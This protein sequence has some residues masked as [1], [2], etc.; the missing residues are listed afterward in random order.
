MVFLCSFAALILFLA[1]LGLRACKNKRTKGS[2]IFGLICFVIF[3]WILVTIVAPLTFKGE[4]IGS[5]TS[6]VTYTLYSQ[7][8]LKG[9]YAYL[10]LGDK[11]GKNPKLYKILKW[12]LRQE[13]YEI[14]NY[15][16]D[17]F[18]VK[19][20]TIASIEKKDDFHQ[21]GKT[22]KVYFIIPVE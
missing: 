8:N 9:E 3:Y 21:K 19:T 17:K 2:G 7:T 10:I 11:D 6:E 16:P 13:N 4:P 12:K 14:S 1:F 22:R 18:K 20:G 5:L 15:L